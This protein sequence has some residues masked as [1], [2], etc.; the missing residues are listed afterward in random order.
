MDAINTPKKFLEGERPMTTG[1]LVSITG[2]RKRKSRSRLLEALEKFQKDVLLPG[3]Q[4]PSP[5][6]N[7]DMEEFLSQVLGDHL[8]GK[9]HS[10]QDVRG[11]AH[12]YRQFAQRLRRAMQTKLKSLARF[13]SMN[14]F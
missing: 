1:T 7:E 4:D 14:S 11:M 13:E 2:F 10:S 9:L 5:W 12:E 6:D 3:S 8:I